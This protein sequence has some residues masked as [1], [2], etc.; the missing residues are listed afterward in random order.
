MESWAA[1]AGTA[2]MALVVMLVGLYYTHREFGYLFKASSLFKI[3][4]ASAVMSA[5][6][7]CLPAE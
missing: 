4:L 1:V 2:L 7:L 3:I 5:F 6:G